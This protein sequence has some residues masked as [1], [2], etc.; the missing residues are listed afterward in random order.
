MAIRGRSLKTIEKEG[1]RTLIIGVREV[2]SRD[3]G[4][5]PKK[6]QFI[7]HTLSYLYLHFTKRLKRILNGDK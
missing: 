4:K 2:Y 3:S 5:F 7:N 1:R 6:L